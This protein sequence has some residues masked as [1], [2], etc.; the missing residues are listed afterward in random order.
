MPSVINFLNFY[1]N[2]KR[3]LIHFDSQEF[4]ENI[5]KPKFQTVITDTLKEKSRFNRLNTVKSKFN[6][7]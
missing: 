5:L 7:L 3:S 2:S 4:E 6:G 1:L